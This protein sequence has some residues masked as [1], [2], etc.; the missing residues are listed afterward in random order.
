MRLHVSAPA[1]VLLLGSSAAV[2]GEVIE[3]TTSAE[4]YAAAEDPDNVDAT[5]ALRAGTYVLSTPLRLRRG[6]AL[7]GENEYVDTDGDQVWDALPGGGYVVA[8]E[9]I[10]DAMALVAPSV[11]LSD[12]SSVA[13]RR[14]TNANPEAAVMVGGGN[15]VS[16][17]TIRAGANVV[18]LGEAGVPAGEPGR[19][20]DDLVGA[21][22][23][24]FTV[25]DV[26]I[27]GG[28]RGTTLGNRGCASAGFH[29]SLV[30]ERNVVTGTSA[31]LSLVNFVTGDND[32][33][34][35]DGDVPD[36]SNGTGPTIA[37]VIRHNRFSGNGLAITVL[38]AA[39]G[40][41]GSAAHI[42]SIGNLLLD[43]TTAVQM[44]AAVSQAGPRRPSSRGSSLR[45]S[46]THDVFR[47]NGSATG[48]AVILMASDRL[49]TAPLAGG[50]NHRNHLEAHLV[51]PTFEGTATELEVVGG[52]YRGPDA[53]ASGTDNVARVLVRRADV[54]SLDVSGGDD[55]PL[56]AIA[57][58]PPN[59]VEWIGA[60]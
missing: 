25:S 35:A 58:S 49:F 11:S 26:V 60:P 7:V 6:M 14:V 37:A 1:L 4:L 56:P 50:P 36:G 51:Q 38:A 29:S 27:A 20:D 48:A 47:R 13:D 54:V 9:T 21:T 31:G 32:D 15:R 44:R 28:A 2:A 34:G 33:E 16:R 59:R 46:S 10:L 17:L 55:V 18:A 5:L 45:W 39:Q 8:G 42:T 43:N 12:C 19:T 22:G 41:D 24:E 40:T 53:L 23:I 30:F 57:P 3:V 52:R